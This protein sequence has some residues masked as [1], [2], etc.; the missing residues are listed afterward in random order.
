V[1][2]ARAAVFIPVLLV[3]FAQLPFLAALCLL[4]VFLPAPSPCAGH[5]HSPACSAL[6]ATSLLRGAAP[7]A[8]GRRKR[9]DSRRPASAFDWRYGA[10]K[11]GD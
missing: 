1:R 5:R 8:C 3:K 4:F 10:G 2:A 11:G 9:K 7:S 6:S